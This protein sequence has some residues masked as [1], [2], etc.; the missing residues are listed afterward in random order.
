MFAFEATHA[1]LIARL[2]EF[3]AGIMSSLD[4][5]FLVMPRGPGYVE[6]ARFQAAY[7]VLRT[8]TRDFS[9][10]GSAQVCRAVD[11]DNLALVVLRAILGFTPSE[12]A[13]LA[14]RQ[15]G[16]RIDQGFCRSLDRRVRLSQVQD[17]LARTPRVQ[18]MVGVACELLEADA[19][20][21]GPGAVHR[22]DKADTKEGWRSVRHLA[23]LGSPYAMLLYERFLGRPFAGHRDSVSELVGGGLETAIEERLATSRVPFRKTKRAER[24]PGF[25]QAPDFFV[26]DEFSPAVV[27]EAK[28]TEDDGTARDKV[29]R[30]QHLSQ[31][32]RLGR[33]EGAPAFQVVAVIAGRGFAVRREDMRK[34]LVSTEGKV[35][36]LR[37]L[38][39]MVETSD[40]LRFRA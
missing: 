30:V 35:Y 10:T 25:D 18:A 11:R 8:E 29:T 28:L 31:L 4:S 36:T 23:A 9:E 34:L 37:T 20:E 2:D 32:A 19:P 15:S 27:I 7:E 3:V 39:R 17:G 26:P 13:H 40:L 21:V 22:L 1:E 24:V 33:P 16:L 5:E 6:Y 38:D 12:W 14:G